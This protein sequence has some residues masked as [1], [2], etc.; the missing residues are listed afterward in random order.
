MGEDSKPSIDSSVQHH[1]KNESKHISPSELSQGQ[2]IGLPSVVS[3]AFSGID[4][5]LDDGPV[6]NSAHH[7]PHV[8]VSQAFSGVDIDLE[9]KKTV[10][11]R[12]QELENL[13]R[14]RNQK[15]PG[16]EEDQ[17]PHPISREKKINTKST[18]SILHSNQDWATSPEDKK[19]VK[20]EPTLRL[21]GSK[22]LAQKFANLVKAFESD[23]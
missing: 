17:Q 15:S 13:S 18:F 21:K 14:S 19:K 20:V 8:T 16:G 9:P 11:Q 7:Q 3:D 22:K 6:S 10:S 12:R 5:D 2:S 4:I 23:A 1:Q